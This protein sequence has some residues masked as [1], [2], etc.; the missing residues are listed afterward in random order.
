MANQLRSKIAIAAGLRS[1][2]FAILDGGKAEKADIAFKQRQINAWIEREDRAREGSILQRRLVTAIERG[3]ADIAEVEK[4]SKENAEQRR[5]T[6]A[7]IESQLF[8]LVREISKLEGEYNNTLLEKDNRARS[9]LQ[10]AVIYDNPNFVEF[11]KKQ[12][13]LGNQATLE[14]LLVNAVSTSDSR[15]VSTLLRMGA[16]VYQPPGA[17]TTLALATIFREREIA[18]MLKKEGAVIQVPWNPIQNETPEEILNMLENQLSR[19]T[20]FVASQQTPSDSQA[21]KTYTELIL[22]FNRCRLDHLKRNI[23]TR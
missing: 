22:Q 20:A 1:T 14:D 3:E 8:M 5:A 4:A 2:F 9:W 11:L 18:Q 17:Y 19:V 6:L 16:R 13:R 15:S 12:V 23:A 21:D 10:R 7:R